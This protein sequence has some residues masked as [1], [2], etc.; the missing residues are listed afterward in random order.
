MD[1]HYRDRS[2]RR[3]ARTGHSADGPF[4]PCSESGSGTAAD[5]GGGG[6]PRRQ[7]ELHQNVGDVALHRVLAE[8]Q[9]SGDGGVAQAVGQERDHL[10]LARAENIEAWRRGWL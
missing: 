4:G 10:A 8:R 6:G 3:F 2:L 5:D 9:L 7:I 1:D